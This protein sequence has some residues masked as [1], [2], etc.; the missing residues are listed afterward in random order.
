MSGRVWVLKYSKPY[1]A[2]GGVVERY[3]L[4]TFALTPSV[5]GGGTHV[6]ARELR[7]ETPRYNLGYPTL[8]S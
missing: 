6:L 1:L 5:T 4:A 7:Q 3:A 2:G 8:P